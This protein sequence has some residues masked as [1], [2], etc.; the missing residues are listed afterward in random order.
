MGGGG[1]GKPKGEKNGPPIGCCNGKPFSAKKRCCCRRKSYNTETEFCCVSPQGCAA[2]QT[3]SNTTEN[4]DAC[5]NIGGRIVLNE[6]F[7]YQ[8][9]P[10]IGWAANKAYGPAFLEKSI[11]SELRARYSDVVRGNGL[12]KHNDRQPERSE[13]SDKNK[14]KESRDENKSKNEE[15]SRQNSRPRTNSRPSK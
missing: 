12:N 2:F 15:K 7:D 10:M 6:Y 5:L 4:R 13:G 11:S 8:A 9:T 1:A 14:E 3:F